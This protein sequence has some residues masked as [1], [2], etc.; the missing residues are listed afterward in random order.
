[1]IK[2]R[3]SLWLPRVV[4]HAT[5]KPSP[6]SQL[7]HVTP[8]L[9]EDRDGLDAHYC[10]CAGALPLSEHQHKPRSVLRHPGSLGHSRL[11]PCRGI[12]G[13]SAVFSMAVDW[14]GFGYAALVTSGG[15]IGYA[16]A[17]SLPSLAAGLFFGSLAGLGAYQVS[18]NP[19]NIWVSLIL[20]MFLPHMHLC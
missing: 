18:Q 20:I 1:M 3:S 19:N 10:S 15:I 16:K 6:N 4:A 7:Y 11:P 17:G 14:L 12:P 5:P 9:D 13:S 8:L 2:A